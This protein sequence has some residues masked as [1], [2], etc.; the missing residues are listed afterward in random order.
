MTFNRAAWQLRGMALPRG[1]ALT[2]VVPIRKHASHAPRVTL[3]IGD[4]LAAA[5]AEPLR[6]YAQASG[7]QVVGPVSSPTV[8]GPVPGQ[9]V[10]IFERRPP[11][12]PEH[13]WQLPIALGHRAP[14]RR[15]LWV[16]V[17]D[18][19]LL[20]SDTLR[21]AAKKAG[22]EVVRPSAKVLRRSPNGAISAVGVAGMAGLIAVW[23]KHAGTSR[24]RE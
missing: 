19:G 15:L 22:I 23:S 2:S 5:L 18:H 7:G 9:V 16:D 17:S 3:L 20:G 14:N 24:V 13:G 1:V 8:N 10:F 21:A 12:A 6:R 11:G 4:G